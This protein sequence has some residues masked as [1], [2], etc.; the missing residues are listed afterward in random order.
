MP[1]FLQC[2]TGTGQSYFIRKGTTHGCGNQEVSH[3]ET[4][5]IWFMPCNPALIYTF[6]IFLRS[7]ILRLKLDYTCPEACLARTL[8]AARI[9]GDKGLSWHYGM[10]RRDSNRSVTS[11]LPM[12]LRKL[13]WSNGD[14]NQTFKGLACK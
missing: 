12:F 7:I 1:S 10:Y 11:V 6:T 14:E 13:C 8:H 3:L 4:G 9:C 5:Y 2:P